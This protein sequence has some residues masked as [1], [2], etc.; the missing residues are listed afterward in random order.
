MPRIRANE[1]CACHAEK[2]N[3]VVPQNQ[4]PHWLFSSTV[5]VRP[6][7]HIKEDQL[8]ILSLLSQLP[9][10][11]N[12]EQ[13][14]WVQNCQG[15]DIPALVNARPLKPLGNPAQNSTRHFVAVDNRFCFR[16]TSPGNSAFV[17]ASFG[18]FQ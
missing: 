2:C 5:L 3:N 18:G 1:L 15:H 10:R 11:L 6:V 8:R 12:A 16:E 17:N 13:T 14:G 9:D 7:L 4:L